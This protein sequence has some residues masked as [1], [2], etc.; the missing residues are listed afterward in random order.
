MHRVSAPIPNS[1][2]TRIVAGDTAKWSKSLPD[3]PAGAG[4][5]LTYTMVNSTNRYTITCTALGDDHL[6]AASAATTAGWVA[7]NYARRAQVALAGEV[8]TVFE[9]TVV[10]LAGFGA[11]TDARSQ[12]RRNLEAVEA[13]LSGRA[14]SAVAEYTIGERQLKYLSVPDLLV[15]R[16]RLRVDVMREDDAT[17]AAAGLGPRGRVVVR[18]GP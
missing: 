3:F 13:M 15:L 1:E 8:Y 4:W 7:G 12:A 17:R 5:V 9:D 18:F 6:A 10:V 16:D 14:S 11:A 2:P